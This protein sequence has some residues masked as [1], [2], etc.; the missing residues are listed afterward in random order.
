MGNGLS[1]WA[2]WLLVVGCSTTSNSEGGAA[3]AA[4][5]S[6]TSG[7]AT[8]SA[9]PYEA[10]RGCLGSPVELEGILTAPAQQFANASIGPV[11]VV[12]DRGLVY[13][14]SLG[15]SEALGTTTSDWQVPL[16][17]GEAPTYYDYSAFPPEA[18]AACASATD[19]FWQRANCSGEV[20]GASGT[21]P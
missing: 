21:G 7:G 9:M 1:F 6:E 19:A 3:G 14:A 13:V 17:T 15:T 16:W 2:A 10:L 11:C 12:S 4:E 20:G 8:L 5:D 18:A